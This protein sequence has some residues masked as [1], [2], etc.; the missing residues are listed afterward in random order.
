MPT[1]QKPKA[2]MAEIL[3]PKGLPELLPKRRREGNRRLAKAMPIFIIKV[4]APKKMSALYWPVSMPWLSA[5]SATIAFGRMPKIARGREATITMS[6]A[7]AS[8]GNGSL[9]RKKTM[10]KF[11]AKAAKAKM[12]TGASE[13]SRSGG[14]ARLSY[15][16]S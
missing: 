2:H 16:F 7:W 5:M 12:R 15:W 3:M 8:G 1:R 11:R 13:K 10:R 6:Q 9:P 4:R 14:A